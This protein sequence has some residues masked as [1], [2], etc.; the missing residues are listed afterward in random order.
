M[1]L[2]ILVLLFLFAQLSC[3]AQESAL[4]FGKWKVVA[5]MGDEFYYNFDIDSTALNNQFKEMLV[6]NKKDTNEAKKVVK[7]SVQ[8][9]KNSFFTFKLDGTYQ[10]FIDDSSPIEEGKYTINFIKKQIF[11]S[12]ISDGGVK[13]EEMYRFSLAG[14]KLELT[15]ALGN[16][17]LI[18]YLKRI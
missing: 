15:M 4:I 11:T 6:I 9:F 10:N 5:V 14:N 1:R 16:D 13:Q 2:S 18:F 12:A 17:D 7:I 3:Y 8:I